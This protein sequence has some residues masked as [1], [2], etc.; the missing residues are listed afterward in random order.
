MD[1]CEYSGGW[2]KGEQ[3]GACNFMFSNGTFYDGEYCQL[4][5]AHKTSHPITK[6][7]QML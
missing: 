7:Q 5:H 6:Y 1:G 4:L 3:H 2:C